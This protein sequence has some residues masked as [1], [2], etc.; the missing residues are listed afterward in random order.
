MECSLPN[1]FR[2]RT[3]SKH[4]DT[5]QLSELSKPKSDQLNADDLLA[6]PITIRI[7][8]AVEKDDPKQNL[9]IYYEGD[10]GKP[11]KPNTGMRRAMAMIW[12]NPDS[13]Q[14]AG[15]S[16][17]LFNNPRIRFGSETTGGI[18]ISHASGLSKPM[19]F[20]LTV[21]KGRREAYTVHPLETFDAELAKLNA[22]TTQ[23]ELKAAFLSLS[24][25]AQKALTPEKDQLK[26]S[27][28][29]K[30]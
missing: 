8:R 18:Q 2:T 7:T 5:M 16:L 4:S 25:A 24:P 28:T 17:T 19:T 1:G 15:R 3:N 27:L 14:L 21:S 10:N 13:S 23:D 22:C 30:N 29:L 26:I 6:G 20:L 12:G 11:Y 9:W